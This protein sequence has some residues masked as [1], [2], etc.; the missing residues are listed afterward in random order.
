MSKALIKFIRLSPTKARLIAR[1]VQGM[2]AEL[3]MASLKFMPNK[4]AK[5][6]ANA[7]SSAVA[8]GGF[9]ANEVIVKSCRV[10]AGAV[11][12]RFR[13]R[14]RG[15]ASRIRKPTSHILVEVAKVETKIEEKAAKKASEKKATATT[16]KT[17][18]KKVTAK[19]ES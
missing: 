1:E 18:T 17:S 13:P 7:I 3:A 9:E 4:G 11:L 8:N 14:A 16:K 5:Y 12:K 6:I 2:N 19:K 15:S 10:D